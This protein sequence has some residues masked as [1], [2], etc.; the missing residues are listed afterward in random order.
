MT[1]PMV[2][3][4]GGPNAISRTVICMLCDRG[5]R[6]AMRRFAGWDVNG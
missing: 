4:H 5:T 3:A 2:S 6:V 1:L